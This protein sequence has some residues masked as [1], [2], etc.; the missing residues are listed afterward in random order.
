MWEFLQEANGFLVGMFGT[1]FLGILG[2]GLRKLYKIAQEKHEENVRNKVAFEEMKKTNGSQEDRLAALEDYQEKSDKRA[3]GLIKAQKASL[4][5]QLWNKAEIY[6]KRG[7]ITVG[8]LNNFEIMYHAYK[9]IGGNHTGDTLHE[10]V[11]ALPVKDEGI[12][13]EDEI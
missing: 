2:A 5:N 8:E 11:K 1:G 4:H 3:K 10:K 6:L 12:L 13:R 7:W 9:A